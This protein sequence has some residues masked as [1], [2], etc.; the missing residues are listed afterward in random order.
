[1]FGFS[2]ASTDLRIASLM[3][4]LTIWREF[5]QHN[6]AASGGADWDYNIG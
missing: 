6:K 5:S 1:M 4:N 2:A 3:V